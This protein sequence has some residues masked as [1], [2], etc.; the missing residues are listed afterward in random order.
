MVDG[1]PT[2][3]ELL[4]GKAVATDPSP[5]MPT[6]FDQV[7]E[8]AVVDTLFRLWHDFPSYLPSSHGA[9]PLPKS[10]A[11]QTR[12]GNGPQTEGATSDGRR[13]EAAPMPA[14]G[15]ADMRRDADGSRRYGSL[16]PRYDTSSN[17]ARTGGRFRRMEDSP[18]VRGARTNYFRGVYA[19][20]HFQMNEIESFV[21]HEVLVEAAR[22]MFGRHHIRLAVVYANLLV[23]GQELAVHTDVPEFIGTRRD[24]IAPWLLVVMRHSGLFEDRR[25]PVAT[26]VTYVGDARGGDFAYYP[27][28]GLSLAETITPA[29]NSAVAFDGDT[30]FHGVD[31]IEGDESALGSLTSNSRLHHLGDRRWVM[32]D[33]GSSTHGF[34]TGDIRFSVS[35]KAL[36]FADAREES[37]FDDRADELADEAIRHRLVE[38]LCVRGRLDSPEHALNERQLADMLIAEFVP[39]P[40]PDVEPDGSPRSMPARGQEVVEC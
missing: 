23:P 7:L 25:I 40:P 27:R 33:D 5:I 24:R 16:G 39:F 18:A 30:I 11:V 21:S 38:E 28:G 14:A 3:R 1:E 29:H 4:E 20:Q 9:A 15:A 36:C 12:G 17:F 19:T 22:E 31:R 10:R 37:E 34:E 2:V 32:D 35:W 6:V 8:P 13:R 26:V